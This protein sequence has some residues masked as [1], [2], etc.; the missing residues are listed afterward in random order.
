MLYVRCI[1]RGH[2]NPQSHMFSYFS[3][4]KRVPEYVSFL[5]EDSFFTAPGI[6]IQGRLDEV[7]VRLALHNTSMS[8]SDGWLPEE[9]IQR[10]LRAHRNGQRQS[11]RLWLLLWRALWFL[12]VIANQPTEIMDA[13]S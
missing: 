11:T 6:L 7:P 9:P 2:V 13:L 5:P 12:I 10:A 1:M 4:E 8:I 3:P